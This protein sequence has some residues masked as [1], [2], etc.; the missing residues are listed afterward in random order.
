MKA[1]F[2]RKTALV[3]LAVA[4][5]LAA[6]AVFAAHEVKKADKT[7]KKDDIYDQV[8][9]FGNAVSAI[10]SDYVTEVESRKI[11]YGAMRGMLS[12]LDDF[13][14][15][16]D[17]D[18]FKEVSAEAKGEFG[19]IGVEITVKEGII[20][21]ITPIAGTPADK[22]GIKPGDKIV[23]I[24]GKSTEDMTI[25]DAVKLMRGDPGTQ[26]MLTVWREKDEK[27][28]DIP[29]K[30][31]IINITSVKDAYL[32]EGKTGY[33]RL[34]EFQEKAGRELE[35]A[36]K[37]LEAQGMDAL[38][39]DLRNNPGGLLDAAIDVS[40]KFLPKDRVIVS[41]KGRNQSQDNT[42]KSSGRYLHPE[43]PIVVIVNDGSASASEIVA[44]ALRDNKRAMLIGT[45]T[46]GKA[47]VQTV[48]PLRDGSA[49]KLTTAL[50]HT[51]GGKS[52]MNQ[53]VA[54]DVIVEPKE[55]PGQDNQLREA[56]NLIKAIKV[57]KT[58]APT[59]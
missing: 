59:T 24:D 7:V 49:L 58:K 31:A 26:I 56:V 3:S 55:M 30:R 12:S 46:F 53:G 43:Y 33:V 13:S 19:G 32:I 47:S 21:I 22:A 38:V 1:S 5:V 39:L 9:L 4:A 15:F 51:P 34:I 18:E 42:Y 14:S 6:S 41:T 54:P 57:H 48:M 27:V 8:E 40:E 28:L 37:R 17:P 20:T 16:L 50:Y 52:I 2:N 44:G 23:K 11:I 45:K 35:E 25:N 10:R 36:L 29:I